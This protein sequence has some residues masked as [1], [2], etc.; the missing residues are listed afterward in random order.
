LKP[1]ACGPVNGIPYL[2]KWRC[3]DVQRILLYLTVIVESC[4]G[5]AMTGVVATRGSKTCIPKVLRVSESNCGS[6]Q[7]WSV[8]RPMRWL[9]NLACI[10]FRTVTDH[11]PYSG[12]PGKIMD[13]PNLS[14]GAVLTT[15][16]PGNAANF[17][18]LPYLVSGV[19]Y[20]L[21]DQAI[22]EDCQVPSLIAVLKRRTRFRGTLSTSA[23]YY[24][25]LKVFLNPASTTSLAFS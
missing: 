23:A 7:V 15:R 12:P 14:S 21:D 16:P 17:R 18:C 10:G 8:S 13:F 20:S 2:Q 6:V 5:M 24:L 3:F 11:K 22:R 4:F 19:L 1:R 25:R 9:V